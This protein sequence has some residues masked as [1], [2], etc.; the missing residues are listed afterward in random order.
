MHQWLHVSSR[1]RLRHDLSTK[2]VLQTP[3]SGFR[4][5]Q[6]VP[7]LQEF[8]PMNLWNEMGNWVN[9][10]GRNRLGNRQGL[11]KEVE[12]GYMNICSQVGSSTSRGSRTLSWLDKHDEPNAGTGANFLS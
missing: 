8:P 3:S 9:K 4:A 10:F 11:G 5:L 2:K 1:A 12:T 6:P 7:D